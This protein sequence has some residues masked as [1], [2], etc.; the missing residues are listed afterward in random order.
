MTR[1]RTSFPRRRGGVYVLVLAAGM[2]VTVLG[3]SAVLAARVSTRSAQSTGELAEAR[4]NAQAAVE[5]A[6]FWI[7]GDPQWRKRPHGLWASQRPV[8]EGGRFS[9]EVIDPLD[10][11]LADSEAEAVHVIGTGQKGRARH[12]TQ[13]TLSAEPMAFTCLQTALH[14][15]S[16]LT[17]TG[18]HLSC[19]Q[20]VS[21]NNS[22][23]ASDST[24]NADIEAVNGISLSNCSGSGKR[25]R[26]VP[27]RSMPGSDAFQHYADTGTRV[28]MSAI[29]SSSGIRIIEDVL[30]SPSRN[31]YGGV[32]DPKGVYI[33]D[34]AG[35]P[36][37][38][39][40]CRI[41]GTLVLLNANAPVIRDS[42][43]WSAAVA[44]YPALLVQGSAR[45]ELTDSSL[46]EGGSGSNVNFNPS[47]TPYEGSS[48]TD[49]DDFY[50][51]AIMGL[52]YV[53]GDLETANF[54]TFQ[55]NL[56]VGGTLRATGGLR[57]VYRDTWLKN[58]PPGFVSAY[59]MVV[60]PRSW[61]QL[62]E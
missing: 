35:Q 38:V 43:S 53:S 25:T 5:L 10:S 15:G 11:N 14:A 44:N 1:R 24:L 30:I 4:F 62:T 45:V 8:G 61:K 46:A 56:V 37:E 31:P 55:G 47:D 41:V 29:P 19:S 54:P 18:L 59:R 50:P 23:S 39:R 60:A 26:D 34:C 17:L 2:L 58:P 51:S 28:A 42:V 9:V 48:D 33:I 13:V 12:R 36:L 57:L 52:V 7:K 40:R 20:T 27:R 6:R 3:L 32:T 21:A 49:S 22:V 16:D